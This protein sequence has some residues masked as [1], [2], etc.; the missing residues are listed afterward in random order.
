VTSPARISAALRRRLLKLVRTCYYAVGFNR[1][2]PGKASFEKRL[3]AWELADN[4]GDVPK[5]KDS[6]DAQ[7]ASGGWG[8]LDGLGE[9][10]H[11]AVIVGY[12]HYLK[13]G[14]SVLDVGCGSGVL[15]ERWLPVGYRRYVGVDISEVAVR[16]LQAQQHPDAR[17]VAADAEEFEAGETFDVVVFNESITYFEDPA[18]GFERYLRALSPGGIVIVSCHQQ[19]GRA[20]AILRDLKRNHR[21]LDETVV[22]QG[23]AAWRCTVFEPGPTGS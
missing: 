1:A 22:E 13:P 12:G 20:Q 3:H 2:F 23:D 17:F 10:A 21:V 9:V 4:R 18:R 14:G 7:Y 5:D 15:H 8:F 6:W 16:E 11:Y 19:S